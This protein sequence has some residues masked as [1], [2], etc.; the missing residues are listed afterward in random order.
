MSLQIIKPFLPF[1]KSLVYIARP[2]TSSS[3]GFPPEIILKIFDPRYDIGRIQPLSK[4]D[5]PHLWTLKAE[6]EAA[7][8]RQEIAEGKRTDVLTTDPYCVYRKGKD[9]PAPFL[10]EEKY[11]R[12]FMEMS[13]NEVDAYT[14]L[15][16][17]QGTVIPKFY[18]SGKLLFPPNTRSIEPPAVLIE[19]IHGTTLSAYL[20]A[21]RSL[22]NIPPAIFHPLFDSMSKFKALGV[23]HGDPQTTNILLS[24]P[25]TPTRAILI[26]FGEAG[27]REYDESEEE[28]T[29][30]YQFYN[31]VNTLKAVL[32]ANGLNIKYDDY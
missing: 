6:T 20:A 11:H 15:L 1:T 2:E 23:Y 17:F 32:N 3:N 29:A 16:S 14:Q 5:H 10:L 12:Y 13:K 4:L 28:W 25:E 22:A 31:G 9:K 7:Q 24:P 18:G 27:V 26:D 30:C 8:Y 21:K 19:Y